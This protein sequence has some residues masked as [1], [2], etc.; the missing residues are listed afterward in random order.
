MNLGNSRNVKG[1]A[2]SLEVFVKK[3]CDFSLKIGWTSMAWAKMD[4]LMNKANH[5]RTFILPKQGN[6]FKRVRRSAHKVVSFLSWSLSMSLLIAL[7]SFCS[8]S[9]VEQESCN[10]YYRVVQA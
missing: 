7:V 9:S 3:M 2:F 10:G 1:I 5:D 6:D 4:T 8:G